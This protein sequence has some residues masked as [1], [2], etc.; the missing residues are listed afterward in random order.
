VRLRSGECEPL[1]PVW[2]GKPSLGGRRA[3]PSDCKLNREF[4]EGGESGL[5]RQS[6]W[7][8]WKV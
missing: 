8:L 4:P 1:D 6:L 7:P 5:S 3:E 2:V